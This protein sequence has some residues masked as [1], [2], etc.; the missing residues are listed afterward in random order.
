MVYK[1]GRLRERID[2]VRIWVVHEDVGNEARD[3][4]NG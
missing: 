1:D 3:G 4:G 2:E